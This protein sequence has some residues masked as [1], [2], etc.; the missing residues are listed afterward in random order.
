MKEFYLIAGILVLLIACYDFF[1]T[2]LSGSGAG[3]L[4][5]LVAELAHRL[6]LV[7]SKILGK[8]LLSAS[9]TVVNLF[10]L[11]VW[12]MLFWIG[13]FLIYSHNPDAITNS[14]GRPANT[15]ERLYFTG[16]TLSTLG[17]GNFKPTTAAFELVTSISSFFGF[18][19]FTTSMTYLVSVSSAII[20]KRSLA[21]AIR[22]LGKSPPAV[23]RS[24]T[25]SN[26]SYSYQQLITIQQMVEKHVIS[27]Q[28]YPVIHYYDNRDIASALSV[29]IS[30]LDECVSMLLCN[31]QNPLYHEAKSL[32]NALDQFLQHIDKKYGSTVHADNIPEIRWSDVNLPQ[33]IHLTD[34]VNHD[35]EPRRK[36]LGGL[37]KNEGFSWQNVYPDD[38]LMSGK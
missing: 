28:A 10:I 30:I 16:Y 25:T 34:E 15:V 6:Q 2:T 8:G 12:V 4:T 9:G 26:P 31:S 24:L 32:R 13:L 36:V 14:N 33:G 38:M 22:D 27:H 7:L 5:R 3:L 17:I 21:L 37:L 19:F 20:R 35:L 23:V 29:N 11:L 18:I 1:F